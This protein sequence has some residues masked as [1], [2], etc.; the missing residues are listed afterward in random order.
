M[1]DNRSR[2]R[3]ASSSLLQRDGSRISRP[4]PPVSQPVNTSQNCIHGQM[5]ASHQP[6]TFSSN[7]G[8]I[9]GS[10]YSFPSHISTHPSIYHPIYTSDLGSGSTSELRS[11]GAVSFYTPSTSTS[12]NNGDNQEFFRDTTPSE[13]HSPNDPD[14]ALQGI[15]SSNRKSNPIDRRVDAVRIY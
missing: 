5:H 2:T 11:A 12:S 6:L 10:Q 8:N 14:R 15:S 1:A 4:T 3:R 9:E 13:H 7:G